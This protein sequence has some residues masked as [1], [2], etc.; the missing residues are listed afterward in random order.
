MESVDER[1]AWLRTRRHDHA[2]RPTSAPGSARQDRDRMDGSNTIERPV[3]NLI[4]DIEAARTNG[5]SATHLGI[6]GACAGERESERTRVREKRNSER[7]KAGEDRLQY[8][9][10]DYTTV[11][12]KASFP[13]PFKRNEITR[14]AQ[15]GPGALAEQ[16][17]L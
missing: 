3:H 16:I 5:M 11:E 8:M 1:N 15:R 4:P 12:Y 14:R 13:P 17:R 6:D 9:D 2:P 7:R 10:Y